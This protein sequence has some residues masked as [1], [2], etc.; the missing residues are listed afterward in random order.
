MLCSQKYAE[1]TSHATIYYID[2]C[3]AVFSF[4]TKA[5]LL[6]LCSKHTL[7]KS[8]RLLAVLFN[9]GVMSSP[10]LGM[11]MHKYSPHLQQQPD[12]LHIC[13]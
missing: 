11:S 8:K 1:F 6:G 4:S 9:C 10:W 2:N 13:T 12:P 3:M 5:N 7:K